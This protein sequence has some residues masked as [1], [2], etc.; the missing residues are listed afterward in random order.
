MNQKDLYLDEIGKKCEV[1]DWKLLYLLAK[2]MEPLVFGE[3]LRELYN[4]MKKDKNANAETKAL[5]R[6]ESPT[7]GSVHSKAYLV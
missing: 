3:L 1:G 5:P 2:N 7:E 4:A 6:G